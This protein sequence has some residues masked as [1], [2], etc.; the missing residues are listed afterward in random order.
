[1]FDRKLEE[2]TTGRKFG[3][4]ISLF[5]E[6]GNLRNRLLYATDEGM[7]AVEF[8]GVAGLEG[9]EVAHHDDAA[10]RGGGDQ[11]RMRYS[12]TRGKG[13]HG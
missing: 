10:R 5:R 11:G 4:L 1:M 2:L 7:P 6:E 9:C 12:I 8:E 3:D 13:R